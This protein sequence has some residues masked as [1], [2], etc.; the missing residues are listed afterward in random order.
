MRRK[1]C[2]LFRCRKLYESE[3]RRPEIKGKIKTSIKEISEM[4]FACS[5]WFIKSRLHRLHLVMVNQLTHLGIV[6]Q[7]I[8]E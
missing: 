5:N 7:Y 3:E 2:F 4:G 6:S 1:E 8:D